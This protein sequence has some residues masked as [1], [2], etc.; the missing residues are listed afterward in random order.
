MDY[1]SLQF[2]LWFYGD[3]VMTNVTNAHAARNEQAF[4][5]RSVISHLPGSVNKGDR[6][7]HRSGNG[8]DWP[9]IANQC[10]DHRRCGR[11][12]KGGLGERGR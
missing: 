6:S 9:V 12:E 4:R 8:S 3:W 2:L 1:G 7:R 5:D 11:G 10:R